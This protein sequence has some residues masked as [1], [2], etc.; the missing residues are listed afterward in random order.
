MALADVVLE[1]VE[2][3]ETKAK[4]PLV[5]TDEGWR[6]VGAI[7]KEL[8]RA[9]KASQ[10]DKTASPFP[11]QLHHPLFGGK[12]HA[13]VQARLQEKRRQADL[14]E[15]S[16]RMVEMVGGPEAGDTMMLSFAPVGL[17][18]RRQGGLYRMGE[19]GKLHWEEKSIL[20]EGS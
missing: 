7:A 13:A 18:Y 6:F 15:A 10:P 4:D 14:E 8:R 1:I 20:L 19:D 16:Q 11:Q 3:M 5:P 2:E 9:V 12:D 17:E